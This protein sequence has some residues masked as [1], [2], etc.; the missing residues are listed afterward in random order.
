MI[1]LDQ[2]INY[3][4]Y[5]TSQVKQKKRKQISTVQIEWLMSLKMDSFCF[6]N[7]YDF[8]LH[9]LK[10][11][12]MIIIF[13]LPFQCIYIGQR[14]KILFCTYLPNL[15]FAYITKSL[16]VWCLLVNKSKFTANTLL[17]Q[18]TNRTQDTNK[19]Y[20]TTLL[21]DIGTLFPLG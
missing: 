1:M 10:V 6:C 5:V 16:L 11:S 4:I 13:F 2:I 14:L 3:K 8:I 20:Y 12:L 15:R 7:F 21:I 19:Y 9:V 18:D 17:Q